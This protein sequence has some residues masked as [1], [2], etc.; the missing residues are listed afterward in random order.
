[1]HTPDERRYREAGPA[2][3][4]AVLGL[5]REIMAHHGVP[6]PA[7]A[8]L[9]AVVQQALDSP[10]HTFLVAEEAGEVVALC[11]LLFSLSTWS[12]GPV[13]ELQDMVVRRDKRGR[14]LGRGL[15][16]AAADRARARGC[17]RMFLT[18]ETFNL[19]A[20]AFYRA[21]GLQEKAVLYF[22]QALAGGPVE[23]RREPGRLPTYG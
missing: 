10:G 8:A 21:C 7:E 22:E 19:P 15:L 4:P 23:A 11:A 14:G 1:M 20:H 12:A 17:R 18:A 3:I 5:L 2:D 6:A 13:C 16:A 9:Q